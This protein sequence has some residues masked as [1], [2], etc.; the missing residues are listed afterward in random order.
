M[1]RRRGVVVAFVLCFTAT[2]GA[3][4]PTAVV[5]GLVRDTSGAATPN[6]TVRVINDTARVRH[7]IETNDE[8]ICSASSHPTAALVFCPSAKSSLQ[9]R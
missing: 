1:R 2:S 3:Q 5:N 8:G 6:A 7:M 4:A 9:L